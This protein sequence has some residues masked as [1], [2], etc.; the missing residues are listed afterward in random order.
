MAITQ[1][2]VLIDGQ[3]YALTYNET[4]RAY[5]GVVTP[6]G[7]SFHQPGGYFNAAVT[8]SNDS[9]VTTS[10]DGGNLQ[11]LRLVVRETVGPVLTLVSPAAGFVTTSQPAIT[12]DVTDEPGGSGVDISTLSMA[13]DGLPGTI[14]TTAIPNGYRAVYTPA[15][16]LAEGAHSFTASVSDYDGNRGSLAVS[17]VVD[18]VPPELQLNTYLRVVDTDHVRVS[19]RAW[20]VT[21]PPITLTIGGELVQTDSEGLFAHDA[22]LT[23]GKNYIP[24]SV[25][26]LAGLETTA[27]LYVIRLITDRTQGDVD[28]L[29]ALLNRQDL[30]AL[31]Q[32]HRGAYNHTDFNRVAAA[33]ELLGEVLYSYG[34]LNTYV[35]E[36]VRDVYTIPAQSDTLA[37][38]A[39]VE[40]MRTARP[41]PE[42][43]P[44]TPEDMEGFTFEEANDIEKILVQ[45]NAI[46]PLL[47][48]SWP[49]CGEAMCGEW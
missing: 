12:V 49:L 40:R 8:A 46:L 20:D 23:I 13:V 42:A 6:T 14:T 10:T 29:L 7:T 37:Y 34:Y 44:A 17:Y 18:T 41:L 1:V 38:L 4:T 16:P 39:N 5:E 43:H 28:A 22:P 25:T 48:L 45:V 24:V 36:P 2:T 27:T 35:P 31:A 21:T 3:E 11:G 9:G 15:D 30:N 32:W 47:E 26:D 19:G 33:M